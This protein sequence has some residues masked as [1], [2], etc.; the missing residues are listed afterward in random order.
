MWMNE[1]DV[2]ET[3]ARTAE[4]VDEVP[5][6][7]AAARVLHALME[8][9][10]SN[11]DGWPYWPKP[12]KAANSLMVMFHNRDYALRF[13]NHRDGSPLVDFTEAELT[14][15]LRPIKAFLKRQDVDYNA[16][17]PWAALLPAA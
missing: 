2:V 14:L 6:M 10:N 13:G 17:L 1:H 7:Y 3:L 16:E 12:G 8:W 9:T 5:H 11:S 4:Q 15:A